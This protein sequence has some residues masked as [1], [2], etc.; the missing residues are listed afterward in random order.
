[1]SSQPVSRLLL[2]AAIG[3]AVL[4]CA[5]AVRV[6]H[7]SDEPATVEI[8]NASGTLQVANSRSG[9][10]IFQA[11]GLA[12]GRSV[13]GTVELSNTGTL[14]G[15]LSLAQLDVQNQP[16]PNGGL[17]ST[18][19]QLAVQ[20]ITG[21]SSIPVFSGALGDVGSRPLGSIAPGEARTYRFTASLPNSGTPA[22]PTAGDN[23]YE[24]SRVTVRYV[25]TAT[26]PDETGG[27]ETGGGTG[28][29]GGGTGGSGSGGSPTVAPVVTIKVNSK[30]LL[31]RGVL[32]VTATCDIACRISTY[33]QLPKAKKARKAA[34]TRAATALLGTP[35][36]PGRIRL[37]VNAKSKRALLAA[38]RKKRRVVLQ[39]KLTASPAAGGPARAYTRKVSVKR[40]KPKRR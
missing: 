11:A 14:A 33:A 9:Q 24:G 21:G 27:G 35:G 29:T 2:L 25:W 13:T 39:V 19:V 18:A 5:G 37:K 28:G 16:G 31:K 38:L 30:K 34:K 22:G 3:V 17:L 1:M 8:T 12:P 36:T 26:A 23:A 6:A 40:P 4:G 15:D 10:A 32:D 7:V 20:D